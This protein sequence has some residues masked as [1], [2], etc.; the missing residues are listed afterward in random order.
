MALDGIVLKKINDELQENLPA[1][2]NKINSL[3]D[4]ELLFNLKGQKG[5][6]LCFVSAHSQFNHLKIT[7]R[8]YP[9]PSTPTN[10][11]MLLRKYLENGIITKSEQTDLDR[12]LRWTIVGHNELGEKDV[13]YLFIELMGKYANVI[14][15]DRNYRIMD[16]IKRIPPFENQRRTIHPGA[17]FTYP[18]KQ[19]KKDPF[20]DFDCDLDV[21][22]TAQFA[23]FSPLLSKEVTYRLH[24]GQSFEEIMQDIRNSKSLYLYP[25]NKQTQYHC[26]ELKHL[27]A[28]AQIFPFM[29][30]L[31]HLF[32]AQEEK[33]RIKQQTGD[34]F[35]VVKKELKKNENK[36]IKLEESLKEALD[37][38]KWREYGDYLFAYQ[39]AIPKGSSSVT[40]ERFDTQGTIEIPLDVRYDAKQNARKYF[41]K[42]NKGKSGQIHIQKQ[43]DLCEKEIT[44]F[45]SLNEQ[46]SLMDFNDIKEIREELIHHGY[47]RE[48]KN[49]R[50]KK[51]A[52][53]HYLTIEYDE[54]TT[55]YVGKNNRQN[56]HV[57]FK[58]GRKEDT[59]FHA[60]DY[61][62]SHT[63]IHTPRLNEEKIRLCAMLAAYYSEAR[64]SSSV[65]VAYTQIKNLKKI[66]DTKGSQVTMSSYKTI[67]IDIDKE[68]IRKLIENR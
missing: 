33:D 27:N 45:R 8:S 15:V 4:S 48:K 38:D 57:T 2:I 55:I 44:Y 28:E 64:D 34:V 36:K 17:M 67:Y 20:T 1:R 16:A 54:D 42:Y 29:Q 59:W 19:N 41:Q 21:P 18:D 63:V 51:D 31:D 40:L 26:I 52:P 32:F 68:K 12:Y 39:D 24:N 65:P 7:N 66:P 62:G 10:F 14:L 3:S 6:F 53:L 43:I 60:L 47:I 61:H 22:L 49:A 50:R 30:G 11:T 23:G 58:K 5:K 46:M 13:H 35:R 9:I 56:E 37:C 25:N